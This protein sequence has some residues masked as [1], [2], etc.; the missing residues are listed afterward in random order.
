VALQPQ[1]CVACFGDARAL[2]DGVHGVHVY[3]NRTTA[4]AVY[5]KRNLGNY[6]IKQEGRIGALPCHSNYS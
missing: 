6:T 5:T 3:G 2:T 1:S 4:Y